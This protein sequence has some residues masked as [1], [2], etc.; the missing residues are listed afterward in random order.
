MGTLDLVKL[1]IEGTIAGLLSALIIVLSHKLSEER[2]KLSEQRLN[3]AKKDKE[4][5]EL[6]KKLNCYIS[7]SGVKSLN[8]TI[9]SHINFQ[10][11]PE[12]LYAF[13]TYEN[14]M[15]LSSKYKID[16]DLYVNVAKSYSVMK[17][18]EMAIKY[19]ELSMPN[20]ATNWNVQFLYGVACAN[21]RNC[22]HYLKS[23]ESY[24]NAIIYMPDNIETN[25]KARLYVYRGSI[26]KRIGRLEEAV[27][28]LKYALDNLQI[29]GYEKADALYNI[30]CVYAM[31]NKVPEY[32][33]I[34]AI[35]E[36]EEDNDTID[37]I[38]RRLKEYAP[39]FK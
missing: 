1:L 24:S 35:L 8:D 32:N 2:H 10:I 9:D 38:K 15:D 39:N 6:Y 19:F 27:S 21:S 28:D 22:S 11:I 34:M 30:A 16:P 29:G 3:S 37:R 36:S 18:W 4:I 12:I 20:M 5:E 14:I 26:Y 13:K 7:Q 23:L 33:D 25:M 17:D 31:Q